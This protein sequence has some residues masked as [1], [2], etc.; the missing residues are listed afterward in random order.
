M[1]LL[2]PRGP[3]HVGLLGRCGQNVVLRI[4][5]APIF[6]LENQGNQNFVRHDISRILSFSPYNIQTVDIDHDGDIDVLAPDINDGTFWLEND[7]FQHFIEHQISSSRL[8]ITS[9][10]AADIDHDG[11]PRSDLRHIG[12]VLIWPHAQISSAA[13]IH[14]R[15]LTEHVLVREFVRNQI[16]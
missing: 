15:D 14:L 8:A 3:T 10:W 5:S 7:G 6:W 16:V 4:T 1:A 9:V 2:P 11:D 13:D 12:E